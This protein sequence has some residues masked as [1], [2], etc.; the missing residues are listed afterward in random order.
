MKLLDFIKNGNVRKSSPDI[1]LTK[2]LVK[3][4]KDDLSFL[5]MINFSEKS[6]RKLV[7]NYYDVLRSVLEAISSEKGYK[8]Y[9]HEA[10]VYF[11]KESGE[12]VLSEK[13]DRFRR[14]R[15]SINY[16]GKTISVAESKE[17][18]EDI[19]RAI[20]YLIKKYLDNND[21]K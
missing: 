4:A 10:F 16:Y 14:I 13:F 9:L 20:D 19:K 12:E 21:T 1:E 18:V 7:A 2:S 17:I 15:N 3:T 6:A 5:S 11:L 8:I